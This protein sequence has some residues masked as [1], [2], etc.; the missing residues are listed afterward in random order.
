M[1][2]P[3]ALIVPFLTDDDLD[4]L[5]DGHADP[6]EITDLG[7]AEWAMRH[8]A[9]CDTE[10]AQLE[11]M[12]AEWVDQIERWFG[13]ASQPVRSRRAFF[14]AHLQAW[15]IDERERSG[16]KTKSIDLPS[17]RV[18]TREQKPRVVVFDEPAVVEWAETVG[19]V[20]EVAPAVRKVQ[21]TAL[22]AQV[23][24]DGQRLVLSSGEI[25]DSVPGCDIDPG[26]ITA[27]VK[28]VQP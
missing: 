6:W 24:V 16:G 5:V 23:R 28:S 27:T 15:A 7:A 3:A 1:T 22:R 18:S 21:V 25:L 20:D 8:V 19:V 17:G 2:L 9:E 13:D 4:D 10:L 12:R 26:G 11:T 14:D